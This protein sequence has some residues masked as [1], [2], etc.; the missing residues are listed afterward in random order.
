MERRKKAKSIRKVEKFVTE[1]KYTHEK[2]R[3]KK[4]RE[5]KKEPS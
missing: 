5:K 3:E 2:Q 4:R 1:Q